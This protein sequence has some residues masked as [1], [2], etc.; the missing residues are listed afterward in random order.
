VERVFHM[1]GCVSLRARDEDLLFGVN[2]GGTRVVM[3]EALRAGV[4]RVVHTSSVAA[5][6]PAPWGETA[7]ERQLFTAGHLGIPYVNSKHEGEAEALRMSAR[8]LPVVVVNPAYPFG[9]G[10]HNGR[11]TS[12]VRRFMLGRIP[13]YVSGG[14]NVVHVDDVARGHLL[15]DER[16][17]VG[18]RYILG[19]RNYTLDRLFA[20]LARLSGVEPPPLR[21]SP[22]LA[23]RLAQATEAAGLT[24]GFTVIDAKLAG[25]WWCYRNGK[26]KRDLGFTTTPHEDALE[27]TVAWYRDREAD[28]LARV[29]RSQPVSLKV[30]AAA[31]GAVDGAAGAARRMW[32]LTA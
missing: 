25:Q 22:P 24:T 15:A 3:E 31:L 27:E 18:E 11:T 16:G 10:D 1:A 2:V 28:R 7:D 32:P 8:G 20:D 14:L 26:A 6:G 21:L 17:Q 19:N 12:I 30:A 9:P 4:E 5:I 29:P 23:L 13:A